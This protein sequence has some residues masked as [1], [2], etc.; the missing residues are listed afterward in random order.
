[1]P[2]LERKVGPVI[3]L[4]Q[5]ERMGS[6]RE[7]AEAGLAHLVTEEA[8]HRSNRKYDC[9]DIDLNHD[10]MVDLHRSNLRVAAR[11]EPIRLRCYLRPRMHDDLRW[12]D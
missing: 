12:L 4:D 7:P 10:P 9:G 11:R 6:E 2:N 1:M 8:D 5:V 3:D